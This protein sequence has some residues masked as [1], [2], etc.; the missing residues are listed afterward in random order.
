M[1]D[2]PRALVGNYLGAIQAAESNQSWASLFR[3]PPARIDELRRTRLGPEHRTWLERLPRAELHCHLGGLLERSGQRAVARAVWDGA[4]RGER[5]RASS[6]TERLLRAAQANER[7]E[8]GWPST[9]RIE[10]G[11]LRSVAVARLLLEVDDERLDALLFGVTE[12]R[13]GLARPAERGGHERGF[14]AYERPGELMGSA[15]LGHRAAVDEYARQSLRAAEAQGLR[16]LEL[17]GSPQ[18]YL[19]GSLAEFVGTFAAALNAEAHASRCVLRLLWSLD[20]RGGLALLTGQL[21]QAVKIAREHELIVG[22]DLAGDEQEGDP[23]ELA[24]AFL[25]AFE[26]C[27]PITIHA[28]ETTEAAAVWAA[29][30]H[31]HA[32]RVGHGLTLVDRPDL[33]ERFRNRRILVELCPTSNREVVGFH[34][35]AV[36]DTEGLPQY[37]LRR[38]LKLGIPVTICTDNPA[39][40]RT[41]SVDE[42]I[43]AARM[44]PGGLSLWEILGLTRQAFE[45]AF[46]RA[47]EREELMREAE[48]EV[49]RAC[50]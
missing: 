21:A 28:G 29:S 41:S 30:Y 39:I 20:R 33:A 44:T 19:D 34:D 36:P 18:K 46:L 24:N 26:A 3:L 23:R 17:R 40:S 22:F 7:W 13:I 9:L 1:S 50:G 27:L 5:A 16:Y 6:L 14:A 4:S 15:L 32:D 12:P 10:G 47:S 35:P 8:W 25:P 31:L 42:L 49:F 48:V 43:T 2:T 11:A 38:F 45:H 37:P